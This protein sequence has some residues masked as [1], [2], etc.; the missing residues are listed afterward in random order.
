MLAP[1][2]YVQGFFECWTRK[3]A[4]VKAIALGLSHPLDAFEVTCGPGVAARLVSGADGWGLHAFIPE[5]GY[6]AALAAPA[7]A[8]GTMMDARV[9][10]V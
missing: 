7:D 8:I 6:C 4:F 9:L 1:D 5:P 2:D 3:E 10:E